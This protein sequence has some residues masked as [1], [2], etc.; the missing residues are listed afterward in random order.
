[1]AVRSLSFS[2][3]VYSRVR[4][5]IENDGRTRA[6]ICRDIG[7]NEATLSRFMAEKRG[8]RTDVLD[9]LVA[10]LGGIETLY[11]EFRPATRPGRRRQGLLM[12]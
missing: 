5:A 12:R 11:T 2:E 3:L 8:L 4:D 7:L 10:S 9:R 6:E 1:M